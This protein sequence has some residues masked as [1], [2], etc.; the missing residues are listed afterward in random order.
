M[1]EKST[2][3]YYVETANS[4]TAVA[5]YVNDVLVHTDRLARNSQ[6]RTSINQWI[7][8]GTNRL[9]VNITVPPLLDEVPDDLNASFRVVEYIRTGEDLQQKECTAVSWK[10]DA[11]KTMPVIETAPFERGI[12]VDSWYWYDADQFN[13][14]TL[15]L[16]EIKH[17]VNEFYTVLDGKDMDAL[18]NLLEIKSREMAI[19]FGIP[20]E[21]RFSD[22]RKFFENLFSK[23]DWGM[24]PPDLDGF[25]IY[26]HAEGRLIEVIDRAASPILHSK[27]L[28]GDSKFMLSLYL[29][30]KNGKWVLCR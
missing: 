12:D 21:E 3:F 27:P 20:L 13:E 18:E 8:G 2:P 17:V 19:A 6:K 1:A 30:H 22:Q 7:H 25:F 16:G 11:E 14:A 15:P 28:G 29:A 26:Y 4:K 23:S 10:Y 24:Q 9:K 5:V